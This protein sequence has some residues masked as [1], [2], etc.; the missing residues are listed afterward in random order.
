MNTLKAKVVNGRLVVDEPTELPE[1][2]VLD[3]VVADSDDDLSEEERNALHA[4]LAEAWE[5][6]RAGNVR[7]VEEF[8]KEW[9]RS[10]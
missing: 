7:P 6:A 8:V 10:R 3:L 9:G 1:G 2:T 4:A 5:S